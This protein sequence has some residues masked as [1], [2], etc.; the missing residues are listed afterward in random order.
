MDDPSILWVIAIIILVACSAFFS[1]TETAFSSASKARLKSYANSG[2]KRAKRAL[3]I[4][5][6]YDTA[7]SAVLIGNNIVN[8]G[9]ASI[10]TLLFT[11]LLGPSGAGV[12]TIVLT[13]VVLIFGEVVPKSLAKMNPEKVVM[14][15]SSVL[16]FLMKLFSPLIWVLQ[17][18]V[19]LFS[20]KMCGEQ[21]PTE[22]KA[23]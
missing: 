16:W 8:I 12:S 2:D 13:V 21:H 19:R 14:R 10:G 9:A 6:R 20:N 3:K 1:G 17:Q 22:T 18:I 15:S 11:G 7:L 4:V 23:E 5:D